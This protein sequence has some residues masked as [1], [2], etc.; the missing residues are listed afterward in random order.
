VRSCSQ[1]LCEMEVN[2]PLIICAN[3]MDRI[4]PEQLDEAVALIRKYFVEER[5]LPASVV[6]G[7]NLAAL[8]EEIRIE[9]RENHLAKSQNFPAPN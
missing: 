4:S 3:K 5:I 8:L 1:I 9:I 2:S 6:T 7:Q